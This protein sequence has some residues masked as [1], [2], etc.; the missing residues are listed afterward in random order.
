MKE[1][2]REKVASLIPVVTEFEKPFWDSLQDEKLMVQKCQKCGNVQFPPSP[3]CTHCLSND[4]KWIPCS[5]KATLWSK[6]TFHK[7][8]LEP[9]NDVPYSV[10]MAKLEEGP[11][12][13][14]RISEEAASKTPFDAPLSAAYVKTADGTVVVEFVPA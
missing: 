8:Y 6:V 13:T 2:S 7:F 1:S 11:V 12:V 9:Y 4:V 5:G 14:G 3:V 10:V